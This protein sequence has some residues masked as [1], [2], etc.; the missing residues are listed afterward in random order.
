M[1]KWLWMV[2][3]ISGVAF[4]L[5]AWAEH[6][7]QAREKGDS[8]AIAGSHD[9]GKEGCDDEKYQCPIITKIMK[10][11]HFLLSNKEELALTD[12]QV[13]TIKAVKNDAKKASI[14]QEADM[15]I[16]MIDMMGKL[17]DDTLD[18]EG[19]NTMIDKGMAGMAEQAKTTVQLYAK[20]KDVLTDEQIA[21]A[22]TLWN[23]K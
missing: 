1:K 17:S 19:L 3:F 10:K 13:G 7:G 20:L 2:F 8:C 14:R 6:S 5:P 4:A 9:C 21:K 12:E 16:G 18:V 11:S 15:E 23:K 22:K